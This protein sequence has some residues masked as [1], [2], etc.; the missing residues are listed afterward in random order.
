L[1]L[2]VAAISSLLFACASCE[3]VQKYPDLSTPRTTF[4]TFRRA[5]KSGD[6]EILERC[7]AGLCLLDFRSRLEK[8][9]PEKLKKWYIKDSARAELVPVVW[10]GGGEK[11]ASV[12]AEIRIKG[13][14]SGK[15]RFSF[16]KRDR[17]W[18]I[19]NR[20]RVLTPR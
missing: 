11:L 7:F 10:A 2:L 17:E 9:G 19:A 16:L 3:S 5:W 1:L 13:Q 4:R 14:K 18:K 20:W 6:I 12:E 8:N 15:L